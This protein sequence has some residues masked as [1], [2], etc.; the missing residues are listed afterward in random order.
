MGQPSPPFPIARVDRFPI[1]ELPDPATEADFARHVDL[2]VH[3]PVMNR[4]RL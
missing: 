3:S 1:L 2:P 4:G